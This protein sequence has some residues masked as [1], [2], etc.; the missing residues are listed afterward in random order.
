[1]LDQLLRS[2]RDFA[3]APADDMTVVVM[4]YRSQSEEES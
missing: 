4:M 3:E 2:V 1:M